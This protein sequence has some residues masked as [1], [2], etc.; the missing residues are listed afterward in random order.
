MNI[1]VLKE[2]KKHEY[3]VGL[4]PA[5]ARAYVQHGHRVA[6][7]AG[8]GAGAGYAD[9][10]Y[11]AAGATIG[12]DKAKLAA[13]ADMIVK[14]KEPQP[15]EYDLLR[16]GQIL[17]TY[18]HLAADPGQA[19][20][21]LQRRIIGVAYETIQTA[22]GA[23]PCLQ[24]M[25]EIAGRLAIQ[26]GAKYLEK[27]SGGRGILLGGVPG[28]RRGK[29]AIVGAGVVGLNA[30]K[31]AVGI[32]ADVSILDVQQRRLAYMDDIF[33]SSIQTL[34]SNRA[35]LEL[36]LRECD[37]LVGA[38]LRPGARAPMLIK[39][40]DLK[41]MKPGSVI[42]DVA[43]D[44]GGCTETSHPTSHDQPIYVVDG[45]VHYCVA[46]MPGAV[47]L[48]STL[49]LTNQTLVYGLEL[50]DHGVAAATAANPALARGVNVCDGQVTHASLAESL[51]LPCAPLAAQLAGTKKK[52]RR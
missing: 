39:R 37:V 5:C 12:A 4:T 16:P 42:V 11:E 28:V 8:A 3:R 31:I 21:L 32:G 47:A 23:L 14:V 13:A 22:D 24:P 29:V 51:G 17:F 46:N 30:A 9:A 40:T 15:E 34:F 20:A 2:I 18:L 50:A 43:I 25:S 19:Q 35:N 26:E 27:A 49:A 7:E 45:V 52:A 33:G 1:T 44:Q 38:V 48:T 36:A 6:V 10:E 41:L